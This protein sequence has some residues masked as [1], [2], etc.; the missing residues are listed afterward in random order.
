MRNMPNTSCLQSSACIL[1]PSDPLGRDGYFFDENSDVYCLDLPWDKRL[2]QIDYFHGYHNGVPVCQ[3]RIEE[4][5]IAA[6]HMI[7]TSSLN[8][9]IRRLTTIQRR[10][11]HRDW[12]R[13]DAY[14]SPDDLRVWRWHASGRWFYQYEPWE[15]FRDP[16][17]GKIWIHQESSGCAFWMPNDWWDFVDITG[18][19][20]N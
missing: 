6:V 13:W 20:N 3:T 19:P 18:S 14:T 4:F 1:F 7:S 8:P 16:A 17:S 15:K 9:T 2:Q 11:R 5:D 10:F 12:G